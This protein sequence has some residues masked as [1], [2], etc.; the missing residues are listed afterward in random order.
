MGVRRRK[1]K[2][3]KGDDD[4][5]GVVGGASVVETAV[6]AE[7]GAGEARGSKEEAGAVAGTAPDFVLP[8]S[9]SVYVRTWGCSH[10]S[11][12]AEYM[13]GLLAQH[14]HPLVLSDTAA[15]TADVW[16]LNSCTVKG[17]S[18]ASF[19]TD[20]R[21]AQQLGKKVVVAG[22]VPQASSRDKR[23]EGISIIGVQ[24]IDRVVEVVEETIRG[25]CVQKPD[26]VPTPKS[27][28]TP[29][30]APPTTTTD[31]PPAPVPKPRK[32]GGAALDLPKVRRNTLVEIVPIN[33]G[34]LNQCTYCKT[35]FSRGDLGS[36]P[37][38]AIL[39]RIEHVLQYEG[40]TEVWITSEDVGAW[41]RDLGLALPDLLSPLAALLPRFP[42]AMLRLGMTNPPH[43]RA[44]LASLIEFLNHPQ[45]YAFLHVPVQSGSDKVLRDMRRDYDAQGFWE[46]AIGVRKGVE[47]ATIATDVICGFPTE[48]SADHAAT[49]S[50]LD[51]LRPP[52]LHISQFYPR[53]GTPAARL[54]PC[55]PDRVKKERSREIT[56]LF[57]SYHPYE[58]M[59]GSTVRC[60]VT[61]VASDGVK[62][63]GHDKSYRQVVL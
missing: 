18:E 27:A 50:L 26:P 31:A 36:Y 2:T 44:H 41:G 7:D 56:R 3:A 4:S 21:K 14:G 22:C 30:V 61:D 13:S 63:V 29:S 15:D 62:L 6:A 60:L 24:Q 40:V 59:E 20:V 32:A 34:C 33:T 1:A 58:G 54:T 11:S 55:F 9:Q 46:V 28:T 12:D 38:S 48:T 19:L 10:N 5:D 8:G 43:I 45:V 53:P 25:N 17:P 39:A 42:H 37:P 23:W 51:R 16:L 35:K 47:G 57:D 49:L 52:V